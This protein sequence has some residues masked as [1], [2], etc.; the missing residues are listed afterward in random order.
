MLRQTVFSHSLRRALASVASSNRALYDQVVLTI[1]DPVAEL[2]ILLESDELDDRL[3]AIRAL[4]EVGDE[5]SLKA[6]RRYRSQEPIESMAASE[7][8]TKIQAKGR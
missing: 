3:S 6:L 1:S 2:L 4:G 5:R 8:I 7:A